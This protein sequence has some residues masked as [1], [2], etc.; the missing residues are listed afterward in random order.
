MAKKDPH[1][2]RLFESTLEEHI[3]PVATKITGNIPEW[4]NGTMIRNGPGLFDVGEDS[5]KHWFDGLSL[6]HRFSIEN[7]QVTYQSRFLRSEAYEK[8]MKYKRIVMSEF[9][10]LGIPDPCKN[11]FE[12]FASHFLPLNITDND[13][14]NFMKIGDDL[15]TLTETQ[16]MRKISTE[17]LT[18][19]ENRVDLFR[20]FAVLTQSSH[21]HK[22][23]D[24]CT[25]NMA[26]SYLLGCYYNIVK[27][28]P[29]SG[30]DPTKAAEIIC[31]I[32]ATRWTKPSYYHSFGMTKNYF[33]FLEQS[34]Y[35]DVPRL[36]MSTM[37]RKTVS[38]ALFFDKNEPVRFHLVNREDGS[39]DKT[40]YVSDAMFGMHVINCYEDDGHIIFDM[41]CYEDGNLIS[42]FYLDYLRN[43]DA[44]GKTEF[45]S[46][47]LR[48][49]VLPLNVG[50]WTP[51]GTNLVTLT[52]STA[53]AKLQKDGQIYL[54]PE[55]MSELGIDM[56]CINYE[57]NNARPYRYAYGTTNVPK[58]GFV[59][60]MA[61]ID[62]HTKE[63]RIWQE[64]NC[65]PS[66]P[67]FLPAPGSVEE[68][69]GV[70]MS[71]IVNSQHRSAFLL[72]LDAK[73]FQEVG[74]AQLPNNI[75]CGL[76][77]HGHFDQ[78]S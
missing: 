76:T 16:Y 59:D 40:Q 55:C 61:K 27:F 56:P 78:R 15:Y 29:N 57:K 68:D 12:R 21:P 2:A 31:S 3:E 52:C 72:V 11:I 63:Y 42:K 73:T 75:E 37:R 53:T 41:C 44:Q 70:V 26:S 1:F 36:A 47:Q 35:I 48:R 6:L 25:Y 45:P 46:P 43:G 8:A 24:G 67:M 19:S 22:D 74:R 60:A 49:Y 23:V 50:K 69:D 28:T 17:D 33:I 51:Q 7:G 30:P 66:E 62:L 9:G 58:G 18:S 13:V 38:S 71:C 20:T 65:Y 64:P 4:I 77:F 39:I 32:P 5:Y 10:T 34:L 14:I 54:V